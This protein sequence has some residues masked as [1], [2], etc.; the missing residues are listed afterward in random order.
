MGHGYVGRAS[1]IRRKSKDPPKQKK[2]GWG[3][4]LSQDFTGAKAHN[5]VASFGTAEAVPDTNLHSIR[6]G[7]ERA[8]TKARMIFNT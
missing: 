7:H 2:L 3:T 6:V 8:R 1:R 4:R 5:A